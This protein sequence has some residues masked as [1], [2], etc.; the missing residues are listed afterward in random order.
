MT[1][2][3]GVHARND[4]RASRLPQLRSVTR[5]YT[6]LTGPT[7]FPRACK[8]GLKGI[9]SKRKGSQIWKGPGEVTDT[10]DGPPTKLDIRH[11]QF[12]RASFTDG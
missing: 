5:V 10:T 11:R 8:L 4:G 6:S 7:V 2:I 12:R 3:F 1:M 9:V